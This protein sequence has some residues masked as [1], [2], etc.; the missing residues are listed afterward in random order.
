M[1]NQDKQKIQEMVKENTDIG[2]VQQKFECQC[3]CKISLAGIE[4]HLLTDKHIT[5]LKARKF[6]KL[7]EKKIITF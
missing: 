3:G 7:I 6:E 1:N 5:N 4:R 2:I